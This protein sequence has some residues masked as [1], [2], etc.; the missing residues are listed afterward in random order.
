MADAIERAQDAGPGATPKQAR[1]FST[2]VVALVGEANIGTG[3]LSTATDSP[4]ASA[5]G[6]AVAEA[7]SVGHT[8]ASSTSP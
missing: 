7:S 3:A 5:P 2:S 1:R 8:P 4:E 6:T